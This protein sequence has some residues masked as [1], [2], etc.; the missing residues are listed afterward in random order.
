[1]RKEANSR[2]D[3]RF[4]MKDCGAWDVLRT[5]GMAPEDQEPSLQDRKTSF[6]CPWCVITQEG[7]KQGSHMLFVVRFPSHPS[8]F[9]LSGVYS[10]GYLTSSI[11]TAS[12]LT[13]KWKKKKK[14]NPSYALQPCVCLPLQLM[15]EGNEGADV[16]VFSQVWSREVAA[17]TQCPL[18]A[19]PPVTL[20]QEACMLN[21][22]VFSC[23]TFWL[24][25]CLLEECFLN[26]FHLKPL[27]SGTFY[28]IL[29][30]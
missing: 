3:R 18:G 4:P 25:G 7:G 5:T 1:M 11:V 27:C 28:A 17:C 21:H 29:G 26:L 9:T 6:F 23:D 22:S 10:L 12:H 24:R 19:I 20:Y 14:K 15:P 13:N 16:L 30:R 2:L 8:R